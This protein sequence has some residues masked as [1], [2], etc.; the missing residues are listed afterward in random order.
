MNNLYLL[1]P[2]GAFYLRMEADPCQ[3]ILYDRNADAKI[4]NEELR[5]VFPDRHLADDLFTELDINGLY[6]FTRHCLE[7]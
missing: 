5:E 2:K 3:Y 6:I 4:T 7:V 1:Q